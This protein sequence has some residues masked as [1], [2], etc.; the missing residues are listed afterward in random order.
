MGR[1]AHPRRT[2]RAVAEATLKAAQESVTIRPVLRGYDRRYDYPNEWSVKAIEWDIR[3][4]LEQ[5]KAA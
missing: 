5:K 4:Q 2:T 1:V 3:R